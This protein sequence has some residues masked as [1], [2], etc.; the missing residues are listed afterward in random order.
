M[1]RLIITRLKFCSKEVEDIYKTHTMSSFG[2]ALGYWLDDRGSRVRF[3]AGAGIFLLTTAAR[4][5][6]GSTQAPT[7]A[8]SLG[9]ERPG[10]EADQTP[11]SSAEV[12]E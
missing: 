11:P 6:L 4:T 5:T 1:S 8:P 10:H 7:G 12:K 3:Q 9:V 2:I